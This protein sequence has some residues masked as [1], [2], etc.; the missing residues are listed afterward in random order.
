M[1]GLQIQSLGWYMITATVYHDNSKSP[2]WLIALAFATIVAV[3]SSY[4]SVT[5]RQQ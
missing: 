2:Y 1:T 3:F 4:T 5:N